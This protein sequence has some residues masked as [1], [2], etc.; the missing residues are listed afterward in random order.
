MI[1]RYNKEYSL[2]LSETKNF[3]SDVKIDAI[4]CK[5]FIAR[6]MTLNNMGIGFNL[7]FMM[8]AVMKIEAEAISPMRKTK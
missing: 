2:M 3:F 6:F 1:E 5:D 8:N 4:Q 7:P